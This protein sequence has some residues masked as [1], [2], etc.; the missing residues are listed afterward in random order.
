MKKVLVLLGLVVALV[1]ADVP[2]QA[3]VEFDLI[4]QVRFRG[5]Y[6][7]NFTDFDSDGV[8]SDPITSSGSGDNYSFWPYRALLGVDAD[9]G[10]GVH[11]V[12]AFQNA[13]VWGSLLTSEQRDVVF[14]SFSVVDLFLANVDL[15]EIGGTKNNLTIGRQKIVYGN[16]FLLGDLDWYNGTSHDGIMYS[17]G[18]ISL[19]SR[20][21]R[22]WL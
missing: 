13:D 10:E 1:V 3:A 14:G 8:S 21:V 19:M 17:Y 16:E 12:V 11:A 5:E 15:R 2:T 4:G 6:I 9:F 18:T 20:R 7:E 22:S